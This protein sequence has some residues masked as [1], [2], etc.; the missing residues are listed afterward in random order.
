VYRP[1]FAF[2]SIV[3]CATLAI[4]L[5]GSVQLQAEVVHSEDLGFTIQFEQTVQATP[6]QVYRL[7]VENIGQWWESSHTYSGDSGNLYLEPREKGWFGERLPDNGI[8]QHMEVL[9]VAPHKKL[10][11][12]G[13]LGPLQ[14]FAVTGILTIDLLA[15]EGGTTL[16][17]VY[18]VGGYMPNGLKALAEP[19]DKVL[20]LQFQ[21]LVRLSEGQSLD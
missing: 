19:V 18:H 6:P 10:R 2:W 4:A 9:F 17:V 5:A 3:P 16:R 15:R 12:R 20:T 7:L 11:M 8:V 14:G 1:A 21:R 13:G